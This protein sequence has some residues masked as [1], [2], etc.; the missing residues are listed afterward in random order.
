MG[1]SPCLGHPLFPFLSRS[2]VNCLQDLLRPPSILNAFW[3]LSIFAVV[4]SGESSVPEGLSIVESRFFFPFC[5]SFGP[6]LLGHLT[7]LGDGGR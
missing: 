2:G 4:A 1:P 3:F 7:F 6:Y 5:M